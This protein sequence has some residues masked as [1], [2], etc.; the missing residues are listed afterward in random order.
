MSEDCLYLNV[1]APS[2]ANASSKLPVR[3]YVHGGA[4]QTGEKA[5]SHAANKATAVYNCTW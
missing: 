1:W 5:A 4:L 3:F 2:W